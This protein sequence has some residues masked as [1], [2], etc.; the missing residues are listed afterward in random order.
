MPIFESDNFTVSYDECGEKYV[1]ELT[2]I[3]NKETE[4]VLHFFE[5]NG[6]SNKKKVKLYSNINEY[7]LHINNYVKEY[8]EWMIADTFDGN[9]NLLSFDVCRRTKAHKNMTPEQYQKVIIHEFVHSCQQENQ[10]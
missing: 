3:L 6:L 4:R 5:L 10:S 8:H 1:S 9:I 7:K 2:Y